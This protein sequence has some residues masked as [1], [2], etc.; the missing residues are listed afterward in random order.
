M[1]VQGFRLEIPRAGVSAD[2]ANR[3]AIARN[4]KSNL[5]RIRTRGAESRRCL[6]L[7][8]GEEGP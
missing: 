4:G 6:G 1:G 5:S 3:E 8:W 7:V 2:I